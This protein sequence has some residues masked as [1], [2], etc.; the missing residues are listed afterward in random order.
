[1]VEENGGVDGR[2]FVGLRSVIGK[3]RVEGDSARAAIKEQNGGKIDIESG[4]WVS[5][6]ILIHIVCLKIALLLGTLI[7]K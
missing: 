5:P 3:G 6:S 4:P 7:A 2:H 1:V